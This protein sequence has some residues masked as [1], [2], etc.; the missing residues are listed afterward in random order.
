M[1]SRTLALTSLTS[2]TTTT[3][4]VALIMFEL[5]PQETLFRVRWQSHDR[6]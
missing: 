2:E 4:A 3:I 6:L 1:T 5:Q